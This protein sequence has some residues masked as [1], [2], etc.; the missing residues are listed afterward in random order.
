MDF[1]HLRALRLNAMFLIGAL[2]V[3]YA[4]GMYVNLFVSFPENATDGQLWEFAW[5]QPPLAAHIILA[6]LLLLGAIVALV[7]AVLYKNKGWI[8]ANTVGLLAIL[9]AGASGASFIP[10]QGDIYSYSMSLAFLAAMLAYA[11]GLL[12]SPRSETVR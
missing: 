12:S 3:Q 1:K 8:I 9:A 11:L 7:R 2:V 5:S 6:I 10:S 4:L